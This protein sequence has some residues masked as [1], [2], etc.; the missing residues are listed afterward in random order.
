MLKLE[1]SEHVNGISENI[2]GIP[3]RVNGLG[4]FMSWV[5][6]NVLCIIGLID[7]NF[8]D[9]IRPLRNKES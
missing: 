4:N 3:E 6:C 1:I 2:N 5:Y 8:T 7:K 9:Y